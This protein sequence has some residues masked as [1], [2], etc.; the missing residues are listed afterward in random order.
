MLLQDAHRELRGD[1][2]LMPLEETARDVP[3]DLRRHRFDER[4]DALLHGE[5]LREPLI[6]RHVRV[7]RAAGAD[8][9]ALLQ[10]VHKV[11]H[12]VLVHAVED[13]EDVDEEVEQRAARGDGA[14]D[15]SRH[16]DDLLRLFGL[17]HLLGDLRRGALR[18]LEVF[19]ELDVLQ[20]IALRVGE[21]HE[22]VVFELRDLHGVLA[23]LSDEVRR[24]L[25]QIRAFFGHD[26]RQELVL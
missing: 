26:E 7:V 3:K 23:E 22:E 25:L 13:V 24:L 6:R 9:H 14:V 19:N 1:D 4:L 15:V 18:L 16:V 21:T 12:G 5:R 8:V 17:D 20:D 11:R 2:E 10:Y